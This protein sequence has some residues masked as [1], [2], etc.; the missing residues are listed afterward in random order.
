MLD[1]EKEEED[2]D[3]DDD[4]VRRKNNELPLYEFFSSTLVLPP[5]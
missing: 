3:D 1:V 2:Y 5:S 4:L